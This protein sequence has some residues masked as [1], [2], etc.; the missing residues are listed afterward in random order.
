MDHPHPPRPASGPAGPARIIALDG[1][2]GSGKST[3]GRLLA[4]Q[5]GYLFFDTGAMYRAVTWAA[6]HRAIPLDDE[7][8]MTH[9]AEVLPIHIRQPTHGE[10]DGRAY[11]VVIDGQD[12][13]WAIRA[14][15]VESGVS[16][17]SAW[18]GVRHALVAQQRR[19]AE[20]V[21]Q[22]GGPPGIVMAGRDIGTVVLHDAERKLYLNASPEERARRRHEELL[23]RGVPSDYE[24]TL[25]AVIRRDTLDST[26]AASPLRPADDAIILVTDGLPIERSVALARAAVETGHA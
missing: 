26:R 7:V 15:E 22:P 14:P 13:T 25:A 19:V 12:V 17:V 4:D 2:A 18:P 23:A 10:T 20:N 24:E 21:G 6:Q 1:P 16:Q 5:L 3:V 9:L 8:A 11:S